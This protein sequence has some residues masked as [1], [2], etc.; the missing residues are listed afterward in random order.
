MRAQ[1]S[2]VGRRGVVVVIGLGGIVGVLAG[3]VVSVDVVD[4]DPFW[5]GGA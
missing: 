3:M 2:V 1:G 4:F 5:G